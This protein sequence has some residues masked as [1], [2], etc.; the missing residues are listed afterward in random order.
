[1]TQ[2]AWH[3]EIQKDKSKV[4]DFVQY[5]EKELQDA[6]KEVHIK[7]NVEDNI[8]RLPGIFEHRFRQLQ[9]I[10]AVL[11]QLENEMRKL[12]SET[13]RMFLEKYQRQLSS[14]DA[15]KY[16]DGERAVVDLAEL[17]NEVAYI[18]NQYMSIAKALD[19]KSFMLGH[20]TKLRQA[21][22]EDASI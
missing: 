13:F 4:L 7:G 10:E 20:I 18:R 5:F 15:W 17:I 1:M 8:A 22:L 19:Q 11:E 14:S 6:Q 3:R 2:T 12:K 21:G 9:A 16:V